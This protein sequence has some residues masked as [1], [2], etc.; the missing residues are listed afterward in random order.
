MIRVTEFLRE[1]RGWR[2]A[3]LALASGMIAALSMP[4]HDLWPLLFIVI[5]VVFFM[6]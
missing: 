6:L 4:P 2:R 3:G 5:P 1:A